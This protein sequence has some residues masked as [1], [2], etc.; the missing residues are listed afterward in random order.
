MAAPTYTT[1]LRLR[2]TDELSASAR[3]NLQKIDQL[4]S[5]FL[6]SGTSRFVRS[7]GAVTIEPNAAAVGGS[8]TDGVLNLGTSGHTL[9]EINAYGLIQAYAHTL[10]RAQGELRLGDADSSNYVGLR[11]P[12][13]VASNVI[14]TLPSADGTTAQV[15]QTDG[16]GNLTWATVATD[17]LAES[18]IRIGSAAGLA[19]ATDTSAVGDILASTTG[20]LT[21]KAGSIANADISDSAA[22]NY[23]KLALTGAVL[24]ADL[25]GSIAYSKLVLAGAITNDDL[26]GSI[27]YSKLAALTASRA[28]VSDGS[29]LVSASAVTSTELGYLSGVTSAVQ[30][31]L[32]GKLALA[33][34]TMLGEL[35]LSG[36]PSSSLHA[37]TKQYVDAVANGLKWKASVRVATTAA[38]TL[39]SDYEAGDSVDG[40][41]LVAGDRILIKNQVTASQNGIYTVAASGAPT[42]T[43]DADTAAE[44]NS[45]VVMVSEGTANADRGFIQTSTLT[46]LSDSQSWV[47]NFGT[48]LYTADGQGLELSGS[49]FSLELDGSSL[50]KSASGLKVN[51]S[52]S[53]VGTTDLQ[54][55]T[56]KTLSGAV[57]SDYTEF[58]HQ[59][60]DPS[61][62]SGNDV[63]LYAKSKKLYF[64]TADAITE[65]GAGGSGELTL[66]DNPSDATNWLT[67]S[68]G[69]APTPTTTST[70]GDLPLGGIV[71]TAIKLTADVDDG[72]ETGDYAYY[73]F[74][75]PEAL[76]NRKLKVEFWMRPG[77]NFIA[78][79]WVVA[80]YQGSTRKTL[81]TD[82]SGVTYLP[83][84]TGKFTAYFDTDSN[85]SYTL[86]FANVNADGATQS[87][88]NIAN[89]VVGPGT[90]PQGAVVSGWT[91]YTP[92]W[93]NVTV[94]NGNSRGK[95]RRV[96]DS[97]EYMATLTFGSTTSV[98]SGIRAPLPTGYT[99]VL[100]ASGVEVIGWASAI[101]SGSAFYHAAVNL[102]SSGTIDIT[103]NAGG[104]E[105]NG[106]TP[107]TWTTND[108]IRVHVLVAVNEW[109]G[110]GTGN[111]AQND[112]EYAYNSGTWNGSDTSSFAYGPAGQ[113]MGGTLSGDSIKRVRFQTPIQVGDFIQVEVSEDRNLWTPAPGGVV[114]GNAIV[115]GVTAAGTNLAGIYWKKV[116]GSSTDVDVLFGRYV[117][118][119]ND[120]APVTEWPSSNA[121]WRV[122]KVA[123]GQ[124]V[125]FGAATQTSNGLVKVPSHA[126]NGTTQATYSASNPFDL[127][128]RSGTY[129]P[130]FSNTNN[131]DATPI[132][133]ANACHWIQVGRIVHVSGFVAINP[134]TNTT[135]TYFD[136][137]LPVLPN[138]NFTG[139]TEANG[140]VVH[141]SSGIGSTPSAGFVTAIGSTKTVRMGCVAQD[142]SSGRN[143]YYYFTYVLN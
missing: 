74:T 32:A 93:T 73:S 100:P 10:L 37:A 39:A 63:R 81:S 125:G 3:A 27:S 76:K 21:Y 64:R 84:A 4:G 83:N 26:A 14:W 106:S 139:G 59:A 132:S 109:A 80:V 34:G 6:A 70:A 66:I 136:M 99:P 135:A 77:S 52:G 58:D 98:S 12:A 49:T 91:S 133:D 96:G 126:G 118:M 134:T 54:T 36:D 140:V 120:D 18:R 43:A 103:S 87:V 94:G 40:V 57:V 114:N 9:A 111:V 44:L 41:T 24:N 108:E 79:S 53:P 51:V 141:T 89:V 5:T 29:G 42:R 142:T 105:W 90:Q 38:G 143:F 107:F 104:S 31:Q 25:A 131:L 60:S 46:S 48:G 17:T 33:G 116:T 113:A 55:L 56:Q 50:A 62:P 1:Y 72:S 78:S 22:I 95:W 8:G 23:S 137:T 15:L 71:D 45:A 92:L 2:L 123:G 7:P 68:S 122:R 47:Q 101:D 138:S 28:L 75:L 20:G 69:A 128:V 129:T 30:T 35:T 110:S 115:Q 65:L 97:I 124:A 117:Q 67:V 85:T 11:A 19:T 82:S 16:S 121:Y 130:T 112:V 127:L 86:R 88:L 13:A 61:A 119:A 102:N